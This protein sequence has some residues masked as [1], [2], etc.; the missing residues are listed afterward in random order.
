[1]TPLMHRLPA[2]TRL[3]LAL[4]SSGNQE[5]VLALLVKRAAIGSPAAL[6]KYALGEELLD[7]AKGFVQPGIDTVKNYVQPHIDN[8]VSS[9]IGKGIGD[10]YQNN[11]SWAQPALWGAGIGGALGLGSGLLGRRRKGRAIGDAMTGALL[12]AG[13][14]GA[15]GYL[16]NQYNSQAGAA[17]PEE[18]KPPE[19][20]AR[21]M[22]GQAEHKKLTDYLER[23]KKLQE[24]GSRYPEMQKKLQDDAAQAT[25]EFTQMTMKQR[26]IEEWQARQNAREQGMQNSAGEFPGYSAKSEM[27]P[28][29][30]PLTDRNPIW[31]GAARGAAIGMPTYWAGS[32]I[33][34]SLGVNHASAL[35]DLPNVAKPSALQKKLLNIADEQNLDLTKWH[36]ARAVAS[37]G[38]KG[39][40]KPI[41]DAKFAPTAE[42]A[43][44]DADI[45][46]HALPVSGAAA[47]PVTS[48][49]KAFHRVG[50]PSTY[51]PAQT[52][53]SASQTRAAA[54][55]PRPGIMRT[56]AKNL[57]VLGASGF[58]GSK[59]LQPGQGMPD[60]R[61]SRHI[62]DAMRHPAEKLEELGYEHAPSF[63]N[64]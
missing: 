2:A 7:K 19:A 5:Q 33:G 32:Q 14:G 37:S 45:L 41:L 40:A 56:T 29:E 55:L 34:K 25:N 20:P 6:E 46:G 23:N 52:R 53:L 24:Y 8:A 10:F 50:L 1:M 9:G 28:V 43:R 31:A 16:M 42:L 4:I 63:F 49:D 21:S 64:P 35:Q 22:Q 62:L 38:I 3:D 54:G 13:L 36:N 60:M 27:P 11:K 47:K 15:G 58:L 51:N 44:P 61:D 39:P 17:K 26:P 12:G 48:L 57:G 18:I 30:T 59:Y